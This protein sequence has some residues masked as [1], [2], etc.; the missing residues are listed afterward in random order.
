M[1]LTPFNNPVTPVVTVLQVWPASLEMLRLTVLVP[2]ATQFNP[3]QL[4][5]L[6]GFERIVPP[7]AVQ[8]A[9]LFNEYTILLAAPTAT[10]LVADEQ[11]TLFKVPVVESADEVDLVQL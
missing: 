8:V 9:P 1:Q 11:L 7:A 6:Y 5:L 4:T 2:T 3:T 10:Q